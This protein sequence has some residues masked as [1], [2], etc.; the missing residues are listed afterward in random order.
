M[1]AN[2]QAIAAWSQRNATDSGA[3][4]IASRYLPGSGWGAP[5]TLATGTDAIVIVGGFGVVS[6]PGAARVA[7]DTSGNSFA[8]WT[9]LV[10][11]QINLV[12]SR[13]SGSPELV[14]ANVG[15]FV[16]SYQI[17]SNAS[18]VAFAVWTENCIMWANRY[19]P[20]T[21]WGA[22]IALQTGNPAC[23]NGFDIQLAVAAN[24]DAIAV[25]AGIGKQYTAGVGWLG[26]G[27]INGGV[28]FQFAMNAAGNTLATWPSGSILVGNGDY[29]AGYNFFP[30]VLI[31]GGSGIDATGLRMVMDANGNA[32]VLFKRAEASGRNTIWA[33]VYK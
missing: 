9:Q 13:N 15:I 10:G 14:K 19:L 11:T 20:G 26:I 16:N 7:V 8:M 31:Y 25:R 4:N 21:G 2:G 33:A 28:R 12:A 3:D 1:A 32:I 30:S 6:N 29:V 24:G 5:T 18:G 22:P 27:Q 23:T 17:A